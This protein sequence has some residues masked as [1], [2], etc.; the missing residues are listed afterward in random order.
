M[1][2]RVPEQMFMR[3]EL[4]S[5]LVKEGKIQ[6]LHDLQVWMAG[7][8]EIWRKLYPEDSQQ[9][10]PAPQAH[11]GGSG[12]RGGRGGGSGGRGSYGG[13]GTPVDSATI[14]PAD[15]S[16]FSQWQNEQIGIGKKV[17]ETTNRP[18]A[19]TTW[20]EIADVIDQ[21]ALSS[22]DWGYMKFL[23]EKLDNKNERT[24]TVTARAK[25]LLAEETPFP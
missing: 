25:A 18:W 9:A 2:D 3:G 20:G 15:M 14:R 1:A 5:T 8:S 22:Q 21:D 19:S 12:G 7:M 23:S 16:T 6:D 24:R 4:I 17:C 13:G 10:P 11:G